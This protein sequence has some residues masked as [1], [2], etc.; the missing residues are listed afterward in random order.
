MRRRAI[1]TARRE[2]RQSGDLIM[3]TGCLSVDPDDV[4]RTGIRLAG[5]EIIPCN[6]PT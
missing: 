3:A 1:E 5:A 4:T 2:G 6:S